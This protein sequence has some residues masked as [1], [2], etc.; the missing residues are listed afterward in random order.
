MAE[1]TVAINTEH[2]EETLP[3]TREESRYLVPP[4]D[5]YETEEGLV[6]LADLPGVG[7]DG[8]NI[9]VDD[10]ILTIQGK[11]QHA[12]DK[13]LALQEFELVPFFR[14]F[15]LTDQVAQDKIDA[16]LKHG[17]VTIRLP[18]AEKAKPRR[19]EV[20]VG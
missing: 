12:L 5:I 4:V 16:E 2:E 6:V 15:E 7:K 14:Q 13:E 8:V 10:N 9:R 11:P 1:K 17:V 19:I 3:T 20:Q 18:K